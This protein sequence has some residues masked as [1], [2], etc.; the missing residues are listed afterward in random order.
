M[1]YFTCHESAVGEA[2]FIQHTLRKTVYIV[3][4][5]HTP[6]R[7]YVITEDQ[8]NDNKWRRCAVLEIFRKQT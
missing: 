1:S 2:D 7:M 6:N 4:I 8:Y 5:E 3:I